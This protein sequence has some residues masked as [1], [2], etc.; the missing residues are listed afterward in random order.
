[1]TTSPKPRRS[2]TPAP[3]APFVFAR[4][5]LNEPLITGAVA[6][7]GRQL[8]RALATNCTLIPS[9]NAPTV[10]LG[11]GTGAVSSALL[12]RSRD[13]VLVE[14]NRQFTVR[15]R[16]RFP[17]IEVV[18]GDALDTMSRYESSSNVVSGLPFMAM[19]A[20]YVR[21]LLSAVVSSLRPGGSFTWFGYYG[22]RVIDFALTPEKRR[23]RNEVASMLAELSDTPTHRIMLNVPPARVWRWTKEL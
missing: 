4:R 8:S 10:E 5:A 12:R 15:L 20:E 22:K 13:T 11:A 6:P 19:P 18:C 16:S 17:Q 23:N 7:S 3:N 9:P 21:D 14:S 2:S 1:M